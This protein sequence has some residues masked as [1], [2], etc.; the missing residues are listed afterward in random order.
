MDFQY[1]PYRKK[2]TVKAEEIEEEED[3]IEDNYD[4]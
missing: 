3:Y 4:F 1:D 2:F